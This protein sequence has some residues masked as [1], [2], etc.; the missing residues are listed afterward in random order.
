MSLSK[1]I[2]GACLR[3]LVKQGQ[4]HRRRLKYLLKH[5]KFFL[6]QFRKIASV[7]ACGH[8]KIKLQSMHVMYRQNWRCNQWLLLTTVTKRSKAQHLFSRLPFVVVCVQAFANQS[9][10]LL[11]KVSLP[12][13]S[14]S[15]KVLPWWQAGILWHTRLTCMHACVF[16]VCELKGAAAKRRVC[17]F[18]IWCH[19]HT[20]TPSSTETCRAEKSTASGLVSI[21]VWHFT[22]GKHECE[23]NV[24]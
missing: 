8:I 15:F 16:P 10:A 18:S 3:V 11:S 4:F 2:P 19:T 22:E 20:S 12:S 7:Y 17:F 6:F 9:K 1:N 21:W 14:Y 5:L 23:T 24:V 13:D